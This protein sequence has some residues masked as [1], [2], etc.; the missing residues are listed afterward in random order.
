M[1]KKKKKPNEWQ[2]RDFS[3]IYQKA[4]VAGNQSAKI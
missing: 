3:E 2:L 1:K 4:G